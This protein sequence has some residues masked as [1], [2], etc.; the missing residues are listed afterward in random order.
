VRRSA[1]LVAAALAALAPGSAAQQQQQQPPPPQ[2]HVFRAAVQTV[3][4]YATVVDRA[5]RLVPHLE[6]QHFEIL[7]NG[8]PQPITL[9]KSDVQPISVVIALDTSGSMTLVLDLVKQAAEAFVLRMLPDDRARIFSFDDK[10]V[11]SGMFTGNRDTLVRHLR[12]EVRFGNGTRLWDAL[13]LSLAALADEA[14]RKVILVL[15]DGD[16]VGS[17]RSDDDVLERAQEQDV[18][19]Y[20]IGLRNRYRGGPNGSMIESRPDRGLKSLTQETGGGY[21]ELTRTTELNSTFTRVADELHRQ[22]LMGFSPATLD[23]RVHKLDVRVK[24]AGMTAR[25]RKSYQAGMPQR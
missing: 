1:L 10:F 24:V 8:Q 13:D 17:S 14:A 16:D 2:Q 25:A 4:I 15:S 11:D 9:F 23:G 22:Y 3:P 12:T 6:Q 5:G 18:M 7:D 19:I 21:F 20:A